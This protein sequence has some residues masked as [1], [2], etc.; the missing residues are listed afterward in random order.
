MNRRSHLYYGRKGMNRIKK[1]MELDKNR[2]AGER[3]KQ[4]QNNMSAS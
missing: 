2:V 1:V 4:K 3:H